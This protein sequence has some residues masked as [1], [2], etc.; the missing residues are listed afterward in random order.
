[1]DKRG[2]MAP[3]ADN[4]IHFQIEGPGEIVAT[5]NGD[6]TSF[7]SFQSHDRKTFHGL[8]VVIVRGQAGHTGKIK[9]TARTD[10]L[11]VGMVS[12][13]T[14]LKTKRTGRLMGLR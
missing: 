4:R 9:L 3:R 8:C 10:G 5:D 6:P 11:E 1:M 2:L 13:E 12:I 14:T 7:E